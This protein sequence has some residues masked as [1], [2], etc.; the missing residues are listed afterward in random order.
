[1][2]LSEGKSEALNSSFNVHTDICGS[3]S[4]GLTADATL[5]I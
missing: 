5:A 4:N 2:G 1:M 3:D